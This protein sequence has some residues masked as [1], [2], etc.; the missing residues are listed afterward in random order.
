MAPTSRRAETTESQ[1]ADPVYVAGFSVAGAM[2]MGLIA[3]MLITY[4]RKRASAKRRSI[5]NTAFLSIRGLVKEGNTAPERNPVNVQLQPRGPSPMDSIVT[6]PDNVLSPPRVQTL[7]DVIDYHRQSGTFP[8]P[9]SFALA[10]ASPAQASRSANP[11]QSILSI[12]N[13]SVLSS[14]SSVESSPATGTTRPVRQLFDPV[15]PDELL[16]RVG[17]SLT[18]VQSFDDGWCVVGRD[19]PTFIANAKSMFRP[20]E[21]TGD[22]IEL[23]VVPAWCFLRPAPGLRAR[24]PIRSTSLSITVEVNASNTTSRDNVISWSNF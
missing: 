10:A 17:D 22:E 15:L 3:W 14:T 12:S 20:N 9:F 19:N 8:K 2:V 24:R 21:V 23:G 18:L 16:I 7:D 1:G 11:R 4:S 13:F 5:R 6:L